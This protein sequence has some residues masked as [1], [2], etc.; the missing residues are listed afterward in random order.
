[1]A[2][3]Y[4]HPSEGS[5]RW[6]KLTDVIRD[7]SHPHRSRR[8]D[9]HRAHRDSDSQTPTASAT[10]T[11]ALTP[12]DAVVRVD[13]GALRSEP[14]PYLRHDDGSGNMRFDIGGEY[15]QRRVVPREYHPEFGW[16]VFS[17][18]GGTNLL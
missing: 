17:G 14:V 12:E 5:F 6:R 11:I 4:G 3:F 8:S 9:L 15:L 13:T 7:D 10:P 1:V 16:I 2:S 18:T